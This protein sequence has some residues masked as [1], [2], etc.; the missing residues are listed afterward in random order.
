M[1]KSRVPKPKENTSTRTPASLAAMK[2]PHSWTK[3]MMPST[4]VT[5]R[6][7]VA[8]S[9]RLF[10]I[11]SSKTFYRCFSRNTN[12]PVPQTEAGLRIVF[13]SNGETPGF[14]DGE[15]ASFGV[16]GQD[17]VHG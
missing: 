8:K 4:T 13:V 17:V 3:I 11:N 16:G 15:P 14:L 9:W 1:P 10:P 7:A 6:T 2:C 5:D 12:Q